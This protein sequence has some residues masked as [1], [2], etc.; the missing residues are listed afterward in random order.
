M[1]RFPAPEKPVEE[2]SLEIAEEKIDPVASGSFDGPPKVHNPL[3]VSSI[4]A[5]EPV[6]TRRELWS[7]YC[8]CFL[9]STI[10]SFAGYSQR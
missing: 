3:F 8:T 6:V 2:G 1:S 10:F 4:N 9:S 5:N 7:Y